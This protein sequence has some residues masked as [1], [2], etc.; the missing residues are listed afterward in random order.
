MSIQPTNSSV[1]T[2][3]P[4]DSPTRCVSFLALDLKPLRKK[5]VAP[6]TLVQVLRLWT[7][8][9]VPVVTVAHRFTSD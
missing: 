1:F 6:V 8:I 5:V 3:T 2:S 7:Y 9:V 4:C